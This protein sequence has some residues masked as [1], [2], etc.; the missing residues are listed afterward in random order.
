MQIIAV[1]TDHEGRRYELALTLPDSVSAALTVNE[2]QERLQ[3][4]LNRESQRAAEIVGTA[5]RDRVIL[6][7]NLVHNEPR[8]PMVPKD[9]LKAPKK[10]GPNQIAFAGSDES[11]HVDDKG[12][13]I[14]RF[15]GGKKVASPK[16][17]Q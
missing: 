9:T 17:R 5:E 8:G 12:Q 3:M 15:K 6:R 7:D 1:G 16:G 10:R 14:A 4:L 2:A 11:V 13:E